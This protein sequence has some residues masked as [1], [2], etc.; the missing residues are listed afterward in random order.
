MY[1]DEC[2]KCGIVLCRIRSSDLP[3]PWCRQCARK[4]PGEYSPILAE[5]VN[6]NA[7]A[8]LK[9]MGVPIAYRA[10]TFEGF[11][12][13]TKDQQRA[14]RAAEGWAKDGEPGLFL[15]G[16]CGVGKTHLAT[17]ALLA[18]RAQG[19]SGKFVSAQEL[20]LVCRDSF[21]RNEGLE[22]VLEKVCRPSVLLLDD[23]GA[24][25][26]TPFARETIG[27]LIDRIYRE[28]GSVIATSNYDFE[29]LAEKLDVRTVDRLIELCLAVKLTGS[30]YRQKRAAQR[31]S[32]RNLPASEVLQ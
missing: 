15:C 31:A 3:E 25:N 10:C 13:A 6:Q 2:G 30:S 29:A 27:L 18:M 7:G 11:E 24:E 1:S 20:L 21:R 12:K 17:A 9:D 14:L 19:F 8:V 16:P 5:W 26:P 4:H 22:E 28:Q 32:V 23:L